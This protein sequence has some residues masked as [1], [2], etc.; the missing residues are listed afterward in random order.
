MVL[1]LGFW[2]GVRTATT[3]TS[4]VAGWVSV[5]ATF[6]F[7]DNP[8][9]GEDVAAGDD[10]AAGE[11]V[12]AGDVA[13]R[14]PFANATPTLVSDDFGLADGPAAD[15]YRGLF[16][17]DVR[18]AEL[19]LL[20]INSPDATSTLLLK[21]RK[22]SGTYFQRG[23]LYFV[24]NPNAQLC[25][26]PP[27]KNGNFGGGK[28]R[29]RVIAELGDQRRPNDLIVTADGDAMITITKTG[30]VLRVSNAGEVSVVVDGLSRPNGIAIAP[31]EQTLYVSS[32][33]TGEISS[34]DLTAESPSPQS[35]A[36]M[37]Q[38]DDGYRGDGMTIDRAGTVYCTGADSVVAFDPDGRMLGRL[39][40]PH[41]PI[42]AAFGGREDVDLYVATFGGVYRVSMPA[43]GVS[44]QPLPRHDADAAS[45]AVSTQPNVVYAEIDG[46]KL[47]MDVC[48]PAAPT[49]TDE[50]IAAI[51]VVHG[52]GWKNGDRTKFRNLSRRLAQRGYLVAAIEYRLAREAKFPAA[53]RDCNAA[54]AW[55]RSRSDEYGIDPDRI[56]VVGGSAGGHLAGLMAA[57]AN[58]A[59]SSDSPLRHPGVLSEVPV[60]VAA[61]VVMAG[62]L[63]IVTGSVA[64]RSRVRN[65]PPSN[66]VLW[67]GGTLD[68]KRDLYALADA[69]NKIDSQTPPI[70]FLCGS[71]DSPERNEPARRAIRAAGG[72]TELIVHDG[73]KHGHWNSDRWI[74]RVVDDID[75]FLK[76]HL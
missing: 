24:D 46:R 62:P 8:A 34:I 28:D 63:D 9:A 57:G 23:Q 70:L 56:A 33:D 4:V 38:T 44:P 39:K 51:I 49:P 65:D 76:K 13:A 40:M 26:L 27:N 1:S 12:A 32:F 7:A 68:E 18:R 3:R 54:T 35:F 14:D 41:R 48:R 69:T 64:Q 74:G 58:E 11:D 67:S 22:I 15:R 30:E 43:Y 42:N 45:N 55:L 6:A 53:I 2:G 20:K 25:V 47:L 5:A 59:A 16:V 52:G 71:E 36:Q 75:A 17:P 72:T 31:D 10:V 50:R 61:A 60:D 21:D 19:R 29:V 37:P 66:M 73:A